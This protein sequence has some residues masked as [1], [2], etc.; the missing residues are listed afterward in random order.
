MGRDTVNT[1]IEGMD[2]LLGGGI[3]KGATVLINGPPGAGKTVIALE[4][5]FNQAKKGER[6]LFV[7]TCEPIYKINK[8]ASSL[9]FYDLDLISGGINMDYYGPKEKRGYVEFQDYSLG[10]ISDEQYVGD[11]FDGIQKKVTRRSYEH[12]II[13]SITSINMLL[14]NEIERRKKTLLFSAWV[15]RM[16]CTTLLTSEDYG[17]SG[18]ER[19]LSDAVIDLGR[20]E[21]RSSKSGC[22]NISGMHFRTI[23]VA[24]LRGKR[25]MSGKYFYSISSDGIRIITPGSKPAAMEE[26]TGLTGIK[27][28]DENI[29]GVRYGNI[30]HINTDDA[31]TFDPI[32]DTMARETI[33]SGDGIIWIR[34]QEDQFTSIDILKRRFGEEVMNAINEKRFIMIDPGRSGTP[35]D[36]KN[37]V[38]NVPVTDKLF[39]ELSELIISIMRPGDVRWRV[40]LDIGSLNGST[41]KED[42][43]KFYSDI[44]AFIRN[45]EEILMTYKETYVSGRGLLNT[46]ESRSDGIIDVWNSGGYRL[47]QVKK[48]PGA[49]SFEPY[50]LKMEDDRITLFPF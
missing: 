31:R 13:D 30:W 12:L 10:Q 25:H 6:V 37:V 36:L 41:G 4:Y 8:F 46:I 45:N 21:L 26:N 49:I 39:S 27:D 34:P 5:A 16:G 24:K 48:A 15:S 38:I 19:F 3:P 42:A 33:R 32:L 29:G 1:G 11:F 22:G 20:S 43:K 9:S 2:E 44:S 18:T 17:I 35:K 28:L 14:G 47:L 50:V 40:Y 23:E 7:S